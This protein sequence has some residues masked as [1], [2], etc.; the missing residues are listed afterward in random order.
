MRVALLL[1]LLVGLEASWRLPWVLLLGRWAG[2]TLLPPSSV[3]LLLA[4]GCAAARALRRVGGER[5]RGAAAVALGAAAALAA[6]SAQHGPPRVPADLAPIE[7]PRLLIPPGPATGAFLLALLLWRA[8]LLCGAGAIDFDRVESSFRRGLVA[9]LLFVPI[10]ALTASGEYASLQAA[11]FPSAAAFFFLA[12]TAFALTGLR[13]WRRTAGEAAPAPDRSWVGVMLGVVAGLL[14]L[15]VGASLLLSL[16]LLA[17]AVGLVLRPLL[18]ALAIL[19]LTL[20]LPIAYL[21]AYVAELLRAMLARGGMRA[22]Q[23]FGGLEGVLARLRERGPPVEPSPGLVLASEWALLLLGAIVVALAIAGAIRWWRRR[24]GDE[25]AEELRESVWRWGLVLAALRG[26]LAA[27]RG[28]GA[29]R[30]SPAAAAAAQPPAVSGPGAISVREL[31][32][33]L[34]ALGAARGLARRPST[35]PAEHLPALRSALDPA[36]DLAA[37]TDAYVAARYG[38][39]EPSDEQVAAARRAWERVNALS[40]REP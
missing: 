25:E 28:R 11:A 6:A 36:E 37:L 27:L 40:A 22:G 32:R 23:P 9:L 19:L 13:S 1:L 15:T 35:T 24:E 21:V 29:R 20:A 38:P 8:G 39:T 10:A 2:Q 3:L 31:Y 30:P 17:L 26:W 14:A 4:L 7:L 12:L 5:V 33:R 34:L 16:D 18:T